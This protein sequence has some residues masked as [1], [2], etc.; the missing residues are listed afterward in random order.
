MAGHSSLVQRRTTTASPAADRDDDRALELA[1]DSGRPELELAIRGALAERVGDSK[2]G[3]W[4]GEGVHLGVLGEGDGHALQVQVPSVFFRDWIRDHFSGSLIAAAEAITGRKLELRFAIHDEAEA[5]LGDV[6]GPAPDRPGARPV[7]TVPIPGNPKTP[8]T[9][10]SAPARPGSRPAGPPRFD[11]PAVDQAPHVRPG[12]PARAP[13]RLD[14]FITGGCNRLAHAAAREM[15]ATAGTSFS[16]LLIHGGVGLGKTHLLEATAHGLRQAHPGLNVVWMT[17]EAFTNGFLDAMRAGTL[18]NFRARY[19]NLGALAIDDIHFLATTR[20]TQ[21]EFLHT[22]NALS[23]R[24]VPIILTADQHPR[25]IGKLSDELI[26]RFLGGMVVKLEA[27]DLPTRRAILEAR[28]AARGVSVPAAVLDY[29]AEHLRASVR[30]LE[31]ALHSVIAHALLTGKRLDLTLA[32]TALRD[33]IRHTAAA[34]ALRDVERAVCDLFQVEPDALKSDS[35][36]RA[37]AYPRMLAMYLARKHTGAAYS[38]I[39]RFFGG[40][41]H[42]T[43]I[44]AEKKVAGWLRDEATSGLLPGFESASDLLAELER[45]LGA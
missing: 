17:A 13:R 28:S 18:A 36:A 9:N 2:F 37:V 15:I 25:R 42:S 34:I 3:L 32:K 23:E 4:F 41:N 44:S 35:R 14:D 30:E 24:G 20:A 38:E 45:S 22:F 1:S 16:P 7:T 21:G 11:F 10:P 31:G 33:T 29:I 27:P 43:V 8:L 6:V 40:R 12:P 5:P 26:T 39:G 19:R